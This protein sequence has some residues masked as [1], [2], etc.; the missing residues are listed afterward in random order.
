M[1]PRQRR[2]ADGQFRRADG[3]TAWAGVQTQYYQT[4]GGQSQ[5]I[6]NPQNQLAGIW[7]DDTND[8]SG[9]P[10]T[11]ATAAAGPGNTYTDFAQEA[12]RAVAHFGISDLAN[13]DI[14]IAQPQNFS[15]PNAASQGYCAFHDYVEP[16]FEKGIYNGITPGISYP[17]MPYVLNQGAGCGSN[18]VKASS[19][20]SRSR[21]DT[22]SRRR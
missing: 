5:Y 22:R 20:G 15:D 2:Q 11:T 8:A 19:T 1:R 10:K 14:V 12:A 16:G 7:V 17:N 13:A 18:F 9:L 3:G 4:V 21:S 6:T